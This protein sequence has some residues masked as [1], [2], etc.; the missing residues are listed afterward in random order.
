MVLV[1]DDNVSPHFPKEI[2]GG[3]YIF[4]KYQLLFSD[5]SLKWFTNQENNDAKKRFLGHPR[6]VEP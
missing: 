5:I 3:E 4:F 6:P 2:G 1:E